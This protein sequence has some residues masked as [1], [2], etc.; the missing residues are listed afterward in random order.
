MTGSFFIFYSGLVIGERQ[1]QFLKGAPYFGLHG[2]STIG[3]E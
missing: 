3:V 2:L 1:A